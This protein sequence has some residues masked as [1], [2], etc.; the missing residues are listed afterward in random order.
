MYTYI[1]TPAI[2]FNCVFL[3]IILLYQN[4]FEYI[5]VMF[6]QIYMIYDNYCIQLYVSVCNNIE[7][8]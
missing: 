6:L 7:L 3:F 4:R 2:E 8:F 1:Y 5:F